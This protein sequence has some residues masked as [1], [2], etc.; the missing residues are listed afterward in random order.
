M[1]RKS[2]T[3]G[4][5]TALLKMKNP[6]KRGN[7]NEVQRK[8]ANIMIFRGKKRVKAQNLEI[9][10]KYGKAASLYEDVQD[11]RSARRCLQK[12]GK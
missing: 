4:L 2:E 12:A 11:F 1:R 5:V 6:G 10:G 9:K 7:G 3:S 8:L